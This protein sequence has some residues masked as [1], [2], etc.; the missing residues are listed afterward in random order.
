MQFTSD[1]WNSMD[2]MKKKIKLAPSEIGISHGIGDVGEGLKVNVFRGAKTVELG[3]MGVGK[4]S[5][6]S[7][8]GYNPETFSKEERED[9]RALAR[10]NEVE[11]S[12]HATP[13]VFLSGF[14][15]GGFRK[16]AQ[17]QG[18]HEIKRAIDFAADATDG[19]PVVFHIAEFQRPIFSV[20]G[21]KFKFYPGEEKKAPIYI[22]DKRNGSLSALPRD[23]TITRPLPKKPGDDPY[24]NPAT[25]GK[26]EVVTE[27]KTIADIEQEY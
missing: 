23:A 14:G 9:I 27:T 21:D 26:G 25:N 17:E 6:A 19:G 12:T 22:V 2:E 15:E 24:L 5:R 18:I 8:T 13:N 20:E 1:Y 4:G 7:P 16:E 10:I 3:F 11:V